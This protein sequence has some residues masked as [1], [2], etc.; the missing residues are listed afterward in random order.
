MKLAIN[1]KFLSICTKKPYETKCIINVHKFQI[2]KLRGHIKQAKTKPKNQMPTRPT[3][4]SKAK[5][6]KNVR[7]TK[8]D[9]TH[10]HTHPN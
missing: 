1:L 6:E 2:I 9:P 5:E 3:D 10:T 7:N 4:P 8:P